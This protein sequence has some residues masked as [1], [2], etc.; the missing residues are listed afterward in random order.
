MTLLKT[1]RLRLR[2][3][4]L[5]DASFILELLNSPQWIT[6]IGDRRVT[7]L[8]AAEKYIADR[9]LPL[10]DETGIGAFVLE[11]KDT[12]EIVGTCGLYKRPDLDHPDIGFALLPK[13]LKKG[14]AFEAA[15]ALM[16]YAKKELGISTILGITISENG[17]SR[18]LL[19]KLGLRHI[20]NIKM[21]GDDADLLLYS[22]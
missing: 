18:S 22:T 12:Q 9:Y 2:A 19:E 15:N 17:S 6:N 7:D 11:L 8:K 20:D 4:T 1:E 21:K 16:D 5:Q 13:H 10:Y 3:F 14:Y